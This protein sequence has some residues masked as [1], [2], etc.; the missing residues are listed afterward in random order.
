MIKL[1]GARPIIV[2]TDKNTF[3]LKA[4]DIKRNITKKTTAIIINSPS[5]P[6]GAVYTQDM[7]EKLAELAVK[8]NIFV[9]SDEI[10]EKLIYDRLEHTSIASLDKK[11]YDLTF[12]V[13]G[14]S[15]SYAMT[16]WRIGYIAGR[17]DVIRGVA[18]LQSH[19]TSNPSSISQAA[20]LAAISSDDASV[21]KMAKEFEKRRDVLASGLTKVMGVKFT[22]PQGAFYCFVNVSETGMDGLAFSKKLL[23]EKHVATIPGEPFGMKDYVRF[24]FATNSGDIKEGLERLKE[25]M[26]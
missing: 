4:E 7:L 16:G 21:R 13:N 10:Y 12:V 22:K 9:I 1:A 5:N 15:K 6:T 24:S 23:D 19:S 20:S 26:K 2:E 8:H 18:A 11:I 17:T 14:V 25:W 3:A